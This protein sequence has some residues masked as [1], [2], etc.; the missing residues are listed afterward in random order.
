MKLVLWEDAIDNVHD[1]VDDV[2]FVNLDESTLSSQIEDNGHI[3]QL[4]SELDQT[5][6][7]K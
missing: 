4:S 1:D 2:K 5:S 3:N 7:L 6:A